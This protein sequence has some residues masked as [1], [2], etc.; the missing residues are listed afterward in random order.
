V[1]FILYDLQANT[2]CAEN[3]IELGETLVCPPELLADC[4]N[5]P[6]FQNSHLGPPNFDLLSLKTPMLVFNLKVKQFDFLCPLYPHV[7]TTPFWAPTFNTHP[8]QNGTVLGIKIIYILKKKGRRKI[9]LAPF[10]LFSFSY[11]F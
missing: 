7:K 10:F 6:N 9:R 5:P 3:K 11:F 4:T 2:C 1:S 8:T